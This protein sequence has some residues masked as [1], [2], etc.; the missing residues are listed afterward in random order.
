MTSNITRLLQR[1][2]Y[3]EALLPSLS[4]AAVVDDQVVFSHCQGFTGIGEAS[5]ASSRRPTDESTVYLLASISKTVLA[6]IVLQ[7]VE[8]GELSLDEDI[9]LYLL[10]SNNDRKRPK[11]CNPNI[12]EVSITLRHLLQHRSSLIDD[13]GALCEGSK[14]RVDETTSML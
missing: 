10:N 7:C 6:M 5:E 11:I 3:S 1:P 9:N 8:R 14:W 2:Q 4:I 13:E 12:P